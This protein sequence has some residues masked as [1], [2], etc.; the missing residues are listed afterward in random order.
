M[1]VVMA[2]C[3]ITMH[4]DTYI[5]S[6]GRLS[7]MHPDAVLGIK[8]T[9]YTDWMAQQLNTQMA[10]VSGIKMDNAIG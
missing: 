7:C 1:L 5:G 6:M 3:V 10:V 4:W 2:P 8:T 9:S